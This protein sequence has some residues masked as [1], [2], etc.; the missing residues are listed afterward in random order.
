MARFG[1]SALTWTAWTGIIVTSI[2]ILTVSWIPS[3]IA[4]KHYIY[5]FSTISYQHGFVYLYANLPL[6]NSTDA[7]LSLVVQQR[8]GE[9]VYEAYPKP[10]SFNVTTFQDTDLSVVCFFIDSTDSSAQPIVSRAVYFWQLIFSTGV[11]CAIPAFE[12]KADNYIPGL[13]FNKHALKGDT[14]LQVGQ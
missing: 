8:E 10:F 11:V 14:V 1:G 3:V 7:Y 9:P 2:V 4:R 13:S 5:N 6:R 12:K